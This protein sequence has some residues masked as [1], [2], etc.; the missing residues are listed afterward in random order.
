MLD[1]GGDVTLSDFVGE[2]T[3]AE[4]SW[5]NPPSNGAEFYTVGNEVR[6]IF[7]RGSTRNGIKMNWA[8]HQRK[9]IISEQKD[10]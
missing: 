3:M 5:S 9:T 10:S 4:F 7:N 2:F 6:V 8:V 1:L